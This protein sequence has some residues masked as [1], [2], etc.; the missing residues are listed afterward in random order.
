VTRAPEVAVAAPA[1]DVATVL[2]TLRASGHRVSAPMRAVVVALFAAD[3]PVTAE[4]IAEGSG[5]GGARVELTSVY[6]NLERLQRL[7][8][9]THVHVGHG[10]GLYVLA[11]GEARE[12]LVCERCGRVTTVAPAQLDAVRAVVRDTF[13]YEARFGHFPMHGLCGACRRTAGG[14]AAHHHHPH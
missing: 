8:V 10:A 7:G 1:A 14:A 4:Q 12:Y 2:R 6:R 3:G 9:V 5:R 11:R 13:G